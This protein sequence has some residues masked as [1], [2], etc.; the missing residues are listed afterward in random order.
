MSNKIILKPG[1][2]KALLNRHHWI[3]SGAIAESPSMLKGDILPVYSQQKVLL[4]HAYFNTKAKIF[5]RMLSFGDANPLQQLFVSL[6]AAIELREKFFTKETNAYRLVNGEGDFIPGLIIDRYQDG[7][8]LQIS[9]LGMEKLKS[10]V[11]EFLIKEIR[12]SF[13]YEKS[14]LPSRK[15]EGL[16]PVENLLYGELPEEIQISENGLKFLV[17]PKEGQKTGF[18]ID[19]RE[20]RQQVRDLSKDKR[21]LNCFAYTGGFSV[22]AASGGAQQVD[23]VDISDAAMKMAQRNAH[24]NELSVPMKFYTEDVFEF[25]RRS[26]LDYD[27]IILDPPAFAK[28][29]KDIIPGC[30]GYKD[31]NRVTMQKIPPKSLLLTSSCSYFVDEEL[32]QKVVFQ[33]ASEAKRQVRIIGRHRLAMDHP[34]NIF[35]PEGDYL[36]SLLLYI[37]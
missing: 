6:K 7:L 16:G 9:T 23:S 24:L 18:F 27:L 22:Y 21:V 8:V 5:G 19:H 34:I 2:E 4:G 37:E 1:K 36:K 28:R 14:T 3:F 25:L 35:H 26:S 11:L 33:A 31:I 30:R 15:E 29:Q 32:F 20:M 10:Q 13:I 17:S 12:P